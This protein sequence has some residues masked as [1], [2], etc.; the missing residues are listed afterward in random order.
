ML[1][2]IL[3]SIFMI[4]IAIILTFFMD[5]IIPIVTIWVINGLLIFFLFL[6]KEEVDDRL[7]SGKK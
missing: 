4:G 2:K 7:S 1:Q 6:E 3:S 5:E